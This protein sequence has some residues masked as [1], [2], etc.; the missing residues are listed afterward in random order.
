MSIVNSMPLRFLIK[1]LILYLLF[2][3]FLFIPPVEH[4]LEEF[5]RNSNN[6]WFNDRIKNSQI[7]FKKNPENSFFDTI[8][9][10]KYSKNNQWN[11]VEYHID[12]RF[13]SYIPKVLF[14]SLFFSTIGFSSLKNKVVAGVSGM[15]LLLLLTHFLLFIRIY[16]M[17]LHVQESLGLYTGSTKDKVVIFFLNNFAS[18]TWIVFFLPVFS[19]I[20]VSSRIILKNLK[21]ISSFEKTST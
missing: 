14:A 11:Y 8:I 17:N 15:I 2:V 7:T 19:W 9:H 4:F 3:G 20:S 5:F 18:Y 16:A 13:I 6:A 10:L 1:S 12:S 21:F